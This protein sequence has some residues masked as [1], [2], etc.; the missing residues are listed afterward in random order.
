MTRRRTAIAVGAVAAVVIAAAAVI[1]FLP[2]SGMGGGPQALIP[3]S[4]EAPTATPTPEQTFAPADPSAE[5][6]AVVGDS[7]SA[8]TDRTGIDQSAGSWT[9]YAPGDGLEYRNTGWAQNGARLAEMQLNLGEV[10]ADVLVILA[11]TNDLTA[12]MSIADRLAIVGQL[13]EQSGAAQI[14]VSAVPPFDPLPSA[15][16]AWNAALAVYAY[17][18]DYT[19][20]DPWLALRTTDGTYAAGQTVDGVHPTTTAAATAG[21]AL[22]AGIVA[23]RDAGV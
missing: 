11:G 6:F 14:V 3:S 10:D 8:R 15:S 7:I 17:Q 23:A 9:S 5:T 19:F 13:A 4:S 18:N 16:T 21:A 12:G 2:A 1:A 22:R 20:V